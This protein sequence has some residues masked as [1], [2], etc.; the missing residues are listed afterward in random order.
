MKNKNKA[1]YIILV[2]WVI[3]TV[4]LFYKYSLQA[5]YWDQPLYAS[6]ALYFLLVIVYKGFNKMIAV[7]F[8]VYIV[9]GLWV[10]ADLFGVISDVL[11]A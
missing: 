2:F 9:F 4:Y 1:V 7:L 10:I 11:G 3:A 6:L 5:G 8:L